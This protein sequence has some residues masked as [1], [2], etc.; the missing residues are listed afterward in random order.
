MDSSKP[1]EQGEVVTLRRFWFLP[2]SRKKAR[3]GVALAKTRVTVR[4]TGHWKLISGSDNY[5]AIPVEKFGAVSLWLRRR[6]NA[7]EQRVFFRREDVV[8][9]RIKV[10]EVTYEDYSPVL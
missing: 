3:A 5:A 1:Y 6:A 4:V 2:Q 10:R 8:Q 9:P 7:M